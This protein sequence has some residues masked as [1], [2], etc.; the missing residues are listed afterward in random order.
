MRR[1][2]LFLLLFIG[3]VTYQSSATPKT[4]GNGLIYLTGAKVLPAGY[5]QFYGSTRYFGQ[6]AKSTT[7]YTFWNVQGAASLNLGISSH[8]ELAVTPIIYQDTNRGEDETKGGYNIPDDLLIGLKVASFGA[9]ESPFVFGGMLTTRFPTGD[10]HNVIYEPYSAGTMEVGLTGLVSYYKNPVFPEEDW[11]V[12]ANL[13]FINHNDAGEDL[14]PDVNSEGLDN[15]TPDAWSSELLFGLGFIYP[16]GTFDFSAEINS[17]FFIQQPPKTAYSREHV[18]YMTTGI[19]YKPY[20][21]LTVEMGVDFKLFSGEDE[22]EYAPV[23]PLPPPP[24]DFPKSYASW[25]GILG[26]KVAILPTHL[27]SSSETEMMRQRAADRKEV[28]ERMLRGQQETEDAESELAK[29]RAERKKVED[30]LQRL[31]KLLEEEK[32]KKKEKG[33]GNEG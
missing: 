16:A 24:S 29:I 2:V 4:G 31:R 5:L 32:K 14:V 1:K 18:T 33:K 28:L 6:V 12:H 11:A 9:M 19:Y 17:R 7:S 25:R 23:T 13:G 26:V 27:Y 20:R 21:W 15:P 8:F 10:L 3:V 30:E 22:T